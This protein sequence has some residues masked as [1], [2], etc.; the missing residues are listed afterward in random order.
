MGALQFLSLLGCGHTELFKGVGSETCGRI[1]SNREV[2][3][4]AM[5]DEEESQ[6]ST[7]LA[8][9]NSKAHV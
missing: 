6:Q 3:F 2:L 1:E 5:T 8:S 7:S 4:C 9:E